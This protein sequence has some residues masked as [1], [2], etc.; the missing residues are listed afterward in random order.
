VPRSGHIEWAI[1]IILDTITTQQNGK[2]IYFIDNLRNNMT[3]WQLPERDIEVFVYYLSERHK[4]EQ[5]SILTSL[6]KS[7]LTLGAYREDTEIIN[8]DKDSV[9]SELWRDLSQALQINSTPA[10]LIAESEIGIEEISLNEPLDQDLEQSS[11]IAKF[12]RGFIT[13]NIPRQ[14]DEIH[15]F[16]NSI[17]ENAQLEEIDSANELI[18]KLEELHR[19]NETGTNTD[20]EWNYLHILG[21]CFEVAMYQVDEFIEQNGLQGSVDEIKKRRWAIRLALTL[22]LFWYYM[23]HP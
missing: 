1:R 22:Y 3:Y 10:L 19:I 12:E 18:G 11:I 7:M 4:R 15:T 17:I 16:L 8:I 23:N 14:H 13:G 21:F 20:T 5:D 9:P 2:N 6:R